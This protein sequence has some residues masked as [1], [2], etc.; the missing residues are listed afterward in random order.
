MF[1]S[2]YRNSGGEEGSFEQEASL[3]QKMGYNVIRIEALNSQ[4][5]MTLRSAVR[6][7]FNVNVFLKAL[8]AIRAHRPDLI[9]VNNLWLGLSPAV[10]WAARFGRV[11]TLQALRNYRIT[12]PSAKLDNAGKCL[13]CESRYYPM[14]CIIRRCYNNSRKQTLLVAVFSLM[15]RLANY[16]R[17]DHKYLAPSDMTR[18]LLVRGGLSARKVRVR[19]NFL[20]QVAT[21]SFEPGEGIVYVGRLSHEKGVAE[22]IR[23]WSNLSHPQKLTL[24]GDGPL[25]GFVA[26]AADK[27]GSPIDWVGSCEPDTVLEVLKKSSLA[28]V[29]SQWAEPFGRVA[30]EAMSVGTPV[31]HTDGGALRE[32]VGETGVFLPQISS[33]ALNKVLLLLNDPVTLEALRKRA[34]SRYIQLYSSS[35]AMR[36]METH[37]DSVS[38]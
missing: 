1:H 35:A 25:A 37:V 2:R 26:Q 22:L 38:R 9:Y 18:D 14:S 23:A 15:M 10:L 4:F 21:P 29:P 31:I 5:D 33:P 12:C 32:I 13:T 34:Y 3:F 7:I 27:P 28:I 30:I 20:M 11:P 8:K 6:A 24:I 17:R 36:D 16:A 19:P